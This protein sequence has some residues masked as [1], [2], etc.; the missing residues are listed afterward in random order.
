MKRELAI[1]FYRVTEAA[2]LAGYKLLGRGDKKNPH[3]APLHPNRN[4]L[5]TLSY[6]KKT[7]PTKI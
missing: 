6:K 5:N 2:A 7:L 4:L 1:E 3:R